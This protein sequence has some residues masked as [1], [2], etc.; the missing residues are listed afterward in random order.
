MKAGPGTASIADNLIVW[1]RGADFLELTKPRITLMVL[2]TTLVGFYAGLNGEAPLLLLANTLFGTAL[3]AGGASALNMYFERHFDALMKRT[4][5]RPLPSGRLQP[6]EALAFASTISIAGVSYLFAAVNAL[7]GALA[8][9]TFLSYLFLYTPLK[10]RTW[11]CTMVGAIPGA[12]PVAIGWAAITGR[13][14]PGAWVLFA[15]VYLWQLP[16]FYAI[17]WIYREDYARGG[18]PMLA[19][20]DS[21]GS[22]SGRQA[23][24]YTVILILASILPSALGMSGRVY[25][26]G[27]LALGAG[28]LAC[29]LRFA[30]RQDNGSA[31]RLFLASIC[32]LPIILALLMID[33]ISP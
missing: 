22:R 11:L 17:A 28:F 12:L 30:R 15:I 20:V 8:T 16:H 19:V 7:T 31:R 24:L 25:L 21:T 27:A 23:V 10:R 3:V 32:Y 2:V 5:D 4:A 9:V 14:S 26:A 1:A 33:K 13:L 18:F 6:R 29:G